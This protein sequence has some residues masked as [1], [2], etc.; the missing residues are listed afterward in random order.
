MTCFRK[1]ILL[2]LLG[3]FS[4][5]LG[6]NVVFSSGKYQVNLLELY[7]SQGC[8]SCPPADRFVSQLKS[9]PDLWDKFIPLAFHVDYW[10]WIGFKDVYSSK[11]STKRQ[12]NYFSQGN[13]KGVYTPGFL[14]NTKEVRNWWELNRIHQANPIRVGNLKGE[15]KQGSLMV[16]FENLKQVK[17]L[18]LNVSILGFDIVTPVDAGENANKTL[19][20]DFVVLSF[21]RKPFDGEEKVKLTQLRPKAAFLKLPRLGIVFWLSDDEASNYFQAAGGFLPKNVF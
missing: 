12:K 10:N 6:N 8:S 7:T 20:N 21:F 19:A 3:K 1:V 18:F 2:I 17:D 16:Q 9:N 5:L 14:L 13:I 4:F 15:I 11:Q